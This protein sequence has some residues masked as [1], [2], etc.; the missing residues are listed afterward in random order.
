M[1][2]T[3]GTSVPSESIYSAAHTATRLPQDSMHF[4]D[5]DSHH[6]NPFFSPEYKLVLTAMPI[7]SPKSYV[8]DHSLHSPVPAASAC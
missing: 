5:L 2:S 6:Q 3:L 7:P 4:H 8:P 1:N